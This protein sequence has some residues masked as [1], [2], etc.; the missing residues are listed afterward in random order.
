MN[1]PIITLSELVQREYGESI[2]TE[3]L[4]KSGQD[5]CPVV[6]VRITLPNGVYRDATGCNKR[7]AKQKG[8]SR[9]VRLLK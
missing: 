3:V 4:G 2:L 9:V 8:S 1:N 5:H 7:V 6:K